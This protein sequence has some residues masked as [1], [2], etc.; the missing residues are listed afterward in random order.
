[1]AI[2]IPEVPTFA[3]EAETLVW[4]RLRDDLPDN[5]FLIAN[6]SR[7]DEDGEFESDLIV[8]W[9]GHGIFLIEVKG[10]FVALE[11]DGEWTSTDRN[12]VRHRIS[13]V[14][15]ATRNA[16]KLADFIEHEWSQGK[17]R[18]PWLLAFPNTPLPSHFRST[19]V[20]RDRVIDQDDL[21][22]MRDRLLSIGKLGG[23][24]AEASLQRC[25]LIADL[26][27]DVRDAQDVVIAERDDRERQLRRLTEEQFEKL[28]EMGDNPR[29]AIVGPAG[30]GKTYLALEQARRCAERGK[31]VAI[32]CFSRGL[33]R[34]LQRVTSSWPSASQPAYVGTFHALA[35]R[36]GVAVPDDAD[37]AWWT[38]TCPALM[39]DAGRALPE[40]ARFDVVVVDEAQD[41][42]P[43]WW[44]AVTSGLRDP[45]HD[46]LYV[47][48]DM[49]QDLFARGELRSLGV[50]I[51]RLT[52][53]MRNARPIAEMASM[54][55]SHPSK[56][57]GM[58]GPPVQYEPCSRED[59]VGVA[60]DM[61]DG[62]LDRGWE[63]RDIVLLTTNHRHPVQAERAEAG[64]D[65][66]WDTLWDDSDIFYAHVT[67]FKGLERPVV[68]LALDGWQ[69]PSRAREYLYV[70]MTRARDL[71][72]VC[73]DPA[74]IRLAATQVADALGA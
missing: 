16:H 18:I 41:F 65:A 51:G 13:P 30:S 43:A 63:A 23:Y 55:T 38:D 45:Q 27:S 12:G 74:D 44:P 60:D 59:V 11:P 2:C 8:A 54:L 32:V 56:H 69:E 20:S 35:V 34:F 42:A 31:R 39:A 9:P 33:A 72:I 62:L 49:D 37:R 15:Q 61:I 10:G 26:L 71:L 48:G 50:A 7:A 52:R 58:S 25:E 64:K 19:H 73:G 70:A 3:S 67:G 24:Q 66:Y 1:M 14:T 5:A 53:N 47:F 68:V 28:E 22:A 4:M 57:L 36:W 40:D 29:F 6:W 21:P 46:P 17:L